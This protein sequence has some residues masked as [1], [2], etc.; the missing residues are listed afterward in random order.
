M[1]RALLLALNA[2]FLLPSVSA[3][4]LVWTNGTN[5]T[6]VEQG[7]TSKACT[8][9]NNPAGKWFEWDAEKD[10]VCVYLYD[11]EE[12]TEP[13]RGSADSYLAKNASSTIYSYKVE[14]TVPSSSSSSRLSGGAIAG[15]VVGV[16][17]GV[18]LIAALIFFVIRHRRKPKYERP[19]SSTPPAY[20]S[21]APAHMETAGSTKKSAEL[22]ARDSTQHPQIRLA[23]LQTSP[24]VELDTSSRVNELEAHS[25]SPISP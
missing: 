16:V 23:E 24:V 21:T 10:K 7:T 17:V 18:L 3:W 19:E 9:M 15:I 2:L 12:C 6:F 14:S 13:S 25:R 20:T 1:R 8:Q 11:N 5:A 4:T 22:S